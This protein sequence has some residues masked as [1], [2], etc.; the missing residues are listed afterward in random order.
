VLRI[1]GSSGGFG[2]KVHQLP[3]PID[4]GTSADLQVGQSVMAIGN[5]FGLDDTLTT[6]IVSAIGRDVNGYGGRPIHGCIQTDAAINPGNSGGPLLD[7]IGRLI[8]VNTMIY[9]PGGTPGNVGIGFAI[10]VDTVR[11]VVNQII[12]Y[13]KIVRP[14]IGINII[15]DRLVK[16]IEQ[17]LPGRTTLDGCL[18]AGVVPNSPAVSAR[19]VPTTQNSVGSLVLGDLITAVNGKPVKESEELIS[20]IEEK[21][22]QEVVTLTVLRKCD[23]NRKENVRIKLT[24]RDKLEQQQQQKQQQQQQKKQQKRNYSIWQ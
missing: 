6:G 5:P 23:P 2:K 22:D 15:D 19:L 7:S 13:G 16:Y 20:E 18:I 9:S 21:D 8:G 11:R 14:S 4:V 17:Q 3:R 10:P 24:T 12:R 1:K